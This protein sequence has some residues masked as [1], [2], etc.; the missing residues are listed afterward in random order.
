MPP[1]AQ[2]QSAPAPGPASKPEGGK[3]KEAAAVPK[4]PS[5]SADAEPAKRATPRKK[6]PK[7]DP[8]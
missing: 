3:A 1:P 2:A 5:M 8:L 7:K 4:V 6:P